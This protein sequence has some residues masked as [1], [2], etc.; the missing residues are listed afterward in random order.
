MRHDTK[1]S[2]Q[3][4]QEGST[5]TYHTHDT[6]A[7]PRPWHRSAPKPAPPTL[8]SPRVPASTTPTSGITLP[9]APAAD[10][11]SPRT[12]ARTL[13]T[14]LDHSRD[15]PARLMSRRALNSRDNDGL[16]ASLRMP[17]RP[18]HPQNDAT[19][20]RGPMP[21]PAGSEGHHG[22]GAACGTRGGGR[23][24]PFDMQD[25]PPLLQTPKMAEN[26]K[27][28]PHRIQTLFSPTP[29][30]PSPPFL[31]PQGSVHIHTR[32]RG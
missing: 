24:R 17:C 15:Y 31:T 12:L 25:A 4:R 6:N 8:A 13:P 21:K 19:P 23:R 11:R 26:P 20:A 2:P 28:S 29:A 7:S 14:A 30:A 3:G 32:V 5:Y 27:H 18:T 1:A 22:G 16:P 9:A 10:D